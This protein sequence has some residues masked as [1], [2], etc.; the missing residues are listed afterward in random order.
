MLLFT[1]DFNTILNPKGATI[2]TFCSVIYVLT[3]VLSVNAHFTS[4]LSLNITILNI[5]GSGSGIYKLSVLTTTFSLFD[6]IVSVIAST[7]MTS[8][9]ISSEELVTY[10]IVASDAVITSVI[11]S[12]KLSP[13]ALSIL[14][15]EFDNIFEELVK[16]VVTLAVIPISVT[17]SN[18][19]VV[20]VKSTGASSVV[21]DITLEIELN[22][23]SLSTVASVLVALLIVSIITFTLIAALS[24]VSLL[25]A[26]KSVPISSSLIPKAVATFVVD[27]L[28]MV[29]KS[30]TI[31]SG[32]LISGS[33]TACVVIACS[34]IL[35]LIDVIGLMFALCEITPGSGLVPISDKVTSIV[36][37]VDISTPPGSNSIL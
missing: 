12:V 24:A 27:S 2:S 25:L 36:F 14:L 34:T 16:A 28:T 21:L 3:P 32:S 35:V 37:P 6:S 30:I 26:I 23:W 7:R 11:I 13:V 17:T 31:G 4:E 19:L 15:K 1:T 18:N 22:T 9:L 5:S 29:D 8:L 10:S 20:S 33:A